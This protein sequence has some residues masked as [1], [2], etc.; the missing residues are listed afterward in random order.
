MK[1]VI[2]GRGQRKTSELIYI[3]WM[4]GDYIVCKDMKECNEV[5]LFAMKLGYNIPLPITY[6]E[7]INGEYHAKGIKGLLIDN[8]ERLLNYISKVPINAISLNP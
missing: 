6:D 7:F 4:T 5:Q 8:V 2:L 3:S 1:K